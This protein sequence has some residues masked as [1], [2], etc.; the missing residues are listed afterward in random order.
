MVGTDR[1]HDRVGAGEHRSQRVV[2]RDVDRLPRHAGLVADRRCPAR[3]AVEH[4]QLDRLRAGEL[5]GDPATMEPAAEEDDL[6]RVRTAG[7]A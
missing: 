6:H 5:V 2:I 3:V 1:V 7:E 4:A